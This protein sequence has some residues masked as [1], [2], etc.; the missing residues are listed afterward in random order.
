MSTKEIIKK[1]FD[2]GINVIPLSQNKIPAIKRWSSLQKEKIDINKHNFESVG[3]I[4]GKISG[5]LEVIDIDCKYDLT[6]KMFE[7]Y[8]TLVKYNNKDLWDK[9]VIQKTKNNGY[10][11]IYRTQQEVQ[12]NQKLSSRP[13]TTEELQH[14]KN[15]KIKVLFET[16]GEGGYIAAYPT[17][18]YKIIHGKLTDIPVLNSNEQDILFSCARSFDSV[19]KEIITGRVYEKAEDYEKTPWEDYNERG[20]IVKLLMEHGWHTVKEDSERIYFR[21]PGKTSAKT[22]AHFHK[23]TELFKVWSSSVEHFETAQPYKKVAV[24]AMLECRGDFSLASKKLSELGYGDRKGKGLVRPSKKSMPVIANSLDV[25]DVSIYFSNEQLE[26]D[27][28]NK[29]ATNTLELGL[30]TGFPHIDHHF[31]FKQ[32]NYV[33]INGHGNVGKSTVSWFLA[34]LSNIMH[35]WKWILFTRENKASDVRATLMEFFLGKDIYAA[36]QESEEMY[37]AIKRWAYSQFHIINIPKHLK[38]RESGYAVIE[39]AEKM[40]KET[41]EKMNLLIDPY[42]SLAQDMSTLDG[43]K[44][45]YDYHYEMNT[46]FRDFCERNGT[47]LYLCVHPQTGSQR[48]KDSNG[49]KMPPGAADTEM[50]SMF[51]NRCDEFLSVHRDT[52]DESRKDITDIYVRKVK[53]IRTGGRPT[54]KENP[55]QLIFQNKI[56]GW[57]GFVGP[58]GMKSPFEQKKLEFKNTGEIVW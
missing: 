44:S 15:E 33:V 41:G 43:R 52:E 26:S 34:A 7:E 6:G 46:E 42:N 53:D 16:R 45:S 32:G 2:M 5:N 48:T 40:M 28:L 27:R 12:G 1:I 35:Q 30:S 29:L 9:L 22:S 47:C 18:G 55:L 14:N 17:E 39:I 51:F 36:K 54:S 38:V 25:S 3:Y 58:N 56:Y 50:G 21:R 31:L 8:R 13:T 23:A 49:N 4:C 19:T 10:H 20:D 57:K 37:S 11:I 24:F